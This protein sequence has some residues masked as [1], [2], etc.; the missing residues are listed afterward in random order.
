MNHLG[1]S[2]LAH[3]HSFS[4]LPC[5]RRSLYCHSREQ[6]PLPLRTTH[7]EHLQNK[8]C[9]ETYELSVFN[10][11]GEKKTLSINIVYSSESMNPHVYCLLLK[12]IYDVVHASLSSLQV[13]RSYSCFSSINLESSFCLC[14]Y[15]VLFCDI[16]CEVV[17]WY[18]TFESCICNSIDF[19]SVPSPR[20]G[21]KPGT[22]C[23]CQHSPSK[24]RYPSLHKSCGNCRARG[25][26]TSRSQSK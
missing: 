24:H 6:H 1:D 18:C 13:F 17:V 3:T 22:L 20:P 12:V 5:P 10:T 11:H 25:T 15:C 23:T 14:Q 19:T 8:I 7:K 9:T 2:V 21:R 26:T 16:Q 4:L